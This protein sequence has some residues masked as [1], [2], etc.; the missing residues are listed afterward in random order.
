MEFEE[1]KQSYVAEVEQSIDF[2]GQSHDFFIRVKADALVASCERQLGSIEER[3]VL[4]VGCG[5]GLMSR[6]VD[7]HFGQLHGIDIAPGAERHI[8]VVAFKPAGFDWVGFDAHPPLV[9]NADFVHFAAGCTPAELALFGVPLPGHPIWTAAMV[10]GLTEM[11]P[12]LDV[13]P[14]RVALAKSDPPTT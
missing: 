8:A 1:Y 7:E 11:Y 12:G 5:V 4:D 9:N 6:Y 14:W 3:S 2:A 10:D 13:E